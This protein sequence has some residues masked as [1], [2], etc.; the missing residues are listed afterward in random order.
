MAEAESGFK[1]SDRRLFTEEG[2]LNEEAA[3]AHEKQSREAVHAPFATDASSAHDEPDLPMDFKTLVFSFRMNALVQLGILANPATNKAE[4]DLRGAKQSIDILEIFNDKTK[5][6][7]DA[8][9]AQ[10]LEA[11]LYELKMS[12]LQASNQVKL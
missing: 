2:E 12:Y 9:E 1:V 6:N 7:L 3:K 8:E 11:S 4:K 10:L 5:G